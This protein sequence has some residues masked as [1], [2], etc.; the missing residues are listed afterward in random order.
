M[1][2]YQQ[3]SESL[4]Q[5]VLGQCT[6]TVIQSRTRFFLVLQLDIT[7]WHTKLG[8]HVQF[9]HSG[10]MSHCCCNCA[11]IIN[12]VAAKILLKL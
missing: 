3:K 10:A 8:F 7:H 12:T 1:I 2:R 9:E 5:N 4:Y 6:N 11:N